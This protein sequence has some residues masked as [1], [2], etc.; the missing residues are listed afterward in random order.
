M[1]AV[2]VALGGKREWNPQLILFLKVGICGG[3]TTFSSFA[4]ETNQLMDQGAGWSAALYVGLSVIGAVAA[5]YGAQL[6]FGK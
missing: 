3:F 6:I 1:E 5:V 2:R 4:L